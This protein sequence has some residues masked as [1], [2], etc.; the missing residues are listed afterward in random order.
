MNCLTCGGAVERARAVVSVESE[1][2][3]GGY[4]RACERADFGRSLDRGWVGS[5]PRC[6]CCEGRGVYALPLHEIEYV[7]TA[8]GERRREGYPV[9]AETPRL[10]PDHA[11]EVFDVDPG[12][13]ETRQASLAAAAADAPSFRAETD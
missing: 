5:G 6:L 8:D 4:C 1:L 9:T 7:E 11:A 10:C 13:R 12:V 3:L 2:R